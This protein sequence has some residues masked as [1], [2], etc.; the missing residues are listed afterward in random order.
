[1]CLPGSN[2]RAKKRCEY[3]TTIPFILPTVVVAAGFNAL[4]GPRGV[5]NALLMSWFDLAVPPIQLLN[6]LAAILLAHV[7]Y[8]TTVIL[9]VV[10]GAWSQL[11]TRLEQAGACWALPG[12]A[13]F[14]KLRCP[15]CARP[16][17]RRRCWFSCSISP[18]SG[19][20]CC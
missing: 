1:M 13:T 16:F 10:G 18:V 12:C 4:I 3:F 19:S 17:Y 6:T 9:R 5:L 14:G 15:C 2:S 8:N 7:F 11:D 20:S